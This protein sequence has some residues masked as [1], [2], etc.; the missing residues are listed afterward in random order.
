MKSESSI[1]PETL[2][3]L[4]DGRLSEQ[5][6]AEV[7]TQLA[8]ADRST[9]EAFMD[10]A[11]IA[12]EFSA[13]ETGEVSTSK[14]PVLRRRNIQTG[15][16]LW[17]VG[18]TTALLAAAAAAVVMIRTHLSDVEY[19]PAAYVAAISTST[20]RPAASLIGANR[21]V[22]NNPAGRTRA[23][24]LGM[25]LTAVEVGVRTG[26]DVRRELAAISAL[27]GTVAGANALAQTYESFEADSHSLADV[28]KRQLSGRSAMTLVGLLFARTGAYL[29][30]ARV[31]SEA[32]DESFFDH[33][34]TDDLRAAATSN[35]ID[36]SQRTD[37]LR[38]VSEVT[39]Q[40]RDLLAIQLTAE[41]LL[42]GL[43]N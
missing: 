20:I 36:A 14:L 38:L 10:A 6:A 19:A 7:R 1:D 39:S 17:L 15:R 31:A 41:S 26:N 4:L 27:L 30:S 9:V 21:G 8:R 29:E 23:V 43:A 13:A 18:A 25:L 37:L 35:T 32:G 33:V 5:R 3:A 28:D 22:E 40:P 42:R 12:D 34:S 24:R 2:A 16:R 11:A